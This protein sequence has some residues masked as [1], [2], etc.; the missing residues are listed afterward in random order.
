[1]SKEDLDLVLKLS[2]RD[3]A[4]NVGIFFN[5]YSQYLCIEF[6][7]N[8]LVGLQQQ[9]L[10]LSFLNVADLQRVRR[11]ILPAVRK[12][13]EREKSHTAYADMLRQSYIG[14]MSE[15]SHQRSGTDQMENI[16]DIRLAF[17]PP[18]TSKYLLNKLGG[19]TYLFT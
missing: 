5:I 13:R 9:Y 8:H 16:I 10:K 14:D 2:H 12:N 3:K 19:C 17:L 4:H 18:H 7:P 11:D 15:F 6:Q 1:M